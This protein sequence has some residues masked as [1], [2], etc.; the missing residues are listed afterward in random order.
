[1][2]S[3]RLRDGFG[4]TNARILDISS[5]GL[6]LRA[7]KTPK[8]GAYVEVCKGPHRIV[9]RVVWVEQ[10]RFGLNTQDLLPI[11]AITGGTAA[12]ASEA[13][14]LFPQPRLKRREA[15]AAERLERSR[16]RSGAMQFL[17]IVGSAAAV[18]ILAFD[19]VEGS[20]S[21]PLSIVSAQ[22]TPKN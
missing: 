19:A 10:D 8:R 11:E 16:R 18:G 2:I 9:A 12:S 5:R 17:W 20:L 22:L 21:R 4:W 6:L 7:S 1:M 3:A 14:Y 13:E 15:S